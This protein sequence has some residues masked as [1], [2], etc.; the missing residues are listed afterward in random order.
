MCYPG[1]NCLIDRL[2]RGITWIF[3]S[4]KT[5]E[6]N[7]PSEIGSIGVRW[8]YDLAALYYPNLLSRVGSLGKYK[9][10]ADFL[11]LEMKM[12]VFKY[13]EKMLF[14]ITFDLSKDMFNCELRCSFRPP[15]QAAL[16]DMKLSIHWEYVF[17]PGALSFYLK[18]HD[19][20][21]LDSSDSIAFA[22]YLTSMII[23]KYSFATLVRPTFIFNYIVNYINDL[24]FSN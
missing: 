2:A 24:K 17:A 6:K 16:A 15:H 8:L 11:S 7:E 19:S 14:A 3:Y 22:N 9:Y 21:I 4:R 1:D 20:E 23:C 12:H 18:L 5:Q 10:F 13:T